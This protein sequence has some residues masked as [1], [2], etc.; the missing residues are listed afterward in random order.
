MNL[1]DFGVTYKDNDFLKN[2]KKFRKFD[3]RGSWN[4]GFRHFPKPN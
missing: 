1:G 2:F 3:A 4:W